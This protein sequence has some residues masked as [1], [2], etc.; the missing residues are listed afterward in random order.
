[1]DAKEDIFI[2]VIRYTL[3]QGK[4]LLLSE[5]FDALHMDQA[6]RDI[7]TREVFYE[8]ILATST[9]KNWHVF[10]KTPEQVLVWASAEDRFRLIDY[11]ELQEARRAAVGANRH[12]LLALAVSAGLAIASIGLTIVQM[13][14]DKIDT[15]AVLSKLEKVRSTMEMIEARSIFKSEGYSAPQAKPQTASAIPPSAEPQ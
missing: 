9:V 15:A 13:R 8:R 14:D 1:M 3:E 4:K 5:I 11:E 12:A 10:D 7:L 6:Q 2:Q